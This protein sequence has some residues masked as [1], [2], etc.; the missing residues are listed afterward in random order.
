[1]TP[2]PLRLSFALAG[3]AVLASGTFS[4]SLL[5]QVAGDNNNGADLSPKPPIVARTAAEQA[6][7]FVL[8]PGYRMEL[9]LSDPDI[10][11]PVVTEFDGNGRMYVIEFVTY[12]P[13]VEG[14]RQRDPRNRITRWEDTDGNGTFDKRTVFAD[15][16]V[17]PRMVL[18]LDKD[19]ILTN[20]TDSDDVIKLT[21]VNGDGVADKREIWYTGVGLNRDGNLEHMQSGFVWG[22]DNWIYS[23]Y[24]AFRFRWTPG[25][26]LREPTGNNGGQWGLSQDD[27]G[28]M[29]FVC[30]GCERGPLNFQ[31]PIQY[32]AY[33]IADEYE[34]NFDI[35]WPIV[36]LADVQGGMGRVRQPI[37]V[38]NHATATA[39]PDIVRA[40]RLPADMQG[41]LLYAEPVGRLIRRAKIV[42]TEGLTQVKNA[43]PFSEFILSTDPLFRPVNLKTA[44]DGTVYVSDMYRGI[45]QEAQ[46]TGPGSYLRMKIFQYQLDKITSHGRI[47][48][49]R[50]DGTAEVPGTPVGPA[51]SRPIPAV[52]ARPAIALD[53]TR[54]RMLNETAAQLVTHLTHPNGWWRDTAQR[55]L[56]L[57]QDKSVVPALQTMARSSDTL[58]ARFHALWTLEGLNA[59]DAG[60][61]RD[62]LKDPS[63]RMRVQAIRASETLYKAGNKSFDADYR[64]ATKD[65]DADVVIQSL[66]TLKVLRVA[67]A[68]DVINATMAGNKARGVQELGKLAVALPAAGPG[69]GGPALPAEQQQLFERG[70]TI[71]NELCFS[72]HGEDGRGTPKTGEAPGATMAPPLAGSA[73][74]QGHRDFVIRTLLH[75]L[76]GPNNGRA[77]T[78]VMIP[79]GTQKD[80]WI[81]SVGSYVRNSFGNT[82]SFITPADVAR[83][84]AAT[85]ARKTSWTVDEID[86]LLPV[87]VQT[88]PTWKTTASHAN[89]NSPRGL[90]LVGWNT[91]TPAQAGMWW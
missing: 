90:T 41:D 75:G 66:M 73:H 7:S 5:A 18:P 61:V 9:V 27:D 31:V 39:G 57:K 80:D 43:Y 21:D 11:N 15:N 88:Q 4:L 46:W 36:G 60:L 56:V 78:E 83:V 17:L 42:K 1:M 65:A 52:A 3:A 77:Y 14:N 67:D 64:A 68:T 85:A 23:T 82:A 89:D 30:A 22:L 32:G 10:V 34:P 51:A 37:G 25:G 55:L 87:L 28:K 8:P 49:L 81:A 33:R 62:L 40:H 19:S 76:T 35:V 79:M 71:Y 6:K 13:D 16:M 50:F 26:I 38:V 54:P 24:N 44:P 69:R 74:V 53:N 72:C 48:R 58:V 59:M 2:V 12:M 91:G 47:W 20:E 70:Q 86:A 29:W 84:R 45:I 63:P